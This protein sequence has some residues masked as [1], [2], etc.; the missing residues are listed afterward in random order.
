MLQLVLG[1]ID[2]IFTNSVE[3][4]NLLARY[5]PGYAVLPNTGGGNNE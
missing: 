3:D 4:A 5:A 2:I 1:G